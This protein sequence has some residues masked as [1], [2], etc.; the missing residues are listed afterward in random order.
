M[1]GTKSKLFCYTFKMPS[2]YKQ[3]NL[4][5]TTVAVTLLC[6]CLLVLGCKQKTTGI[7]GE[8]HSQTTSALGD[9]LIVNGARAT[10][11]NNKS[12]TPVPP[13]EYSTRLENKTLLLEDGSQEVEA[14]IQPD[15][16][17]KIGE[18]IYKKQN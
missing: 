14:E 2:F 1:V 18:S 17:L 13:K 9:I 4:A 5:T 7:N 16:S 8:Y 6:L 15:G 3:I 11:S 10:L 12:G